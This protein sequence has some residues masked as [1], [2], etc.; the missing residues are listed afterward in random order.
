MI[1]VLIMNRLPSSEVQ[2]L[3]QKAV[4]SVQ[5]KKRR[6]DAILVNQISQ[7]SGKRA[8]KTGW[9]NNLHIHFQTHT[10]EIFKIMWGSL[11]LKSKKL[12]EKEQGQYISICTHSTIL[13]E[14]MCSQY[15]TTSA[16]G[17]FFYQIKKQNK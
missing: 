2:I 8:I 15:F 13:T 17:Q 4:D 6:W 7:Q 3:N 11:L 10:N 1:M 14:T 5:N 9:Q 16:H 12:C